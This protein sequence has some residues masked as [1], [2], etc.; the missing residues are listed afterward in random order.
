M[1]VKNLPNPYGFAILVDDNGKAFY[2]SS[3]D[4]L[5]KSVDNLINSGKCSGTSNPNPLASSGPSVSSN[6]SP[7][8]SQSYS[9][10]PSLSP[11][12]SPS[13]SPIDCA[14]LRQKYPTACGRWKVNTNTYV[15][16]PGCSQCNACYDRNNN[17]ISDLNNHGGYCKYSINNPFTFNPVTPFPPYGNPYPTQSSPLPVQSSPGQNPYQPPSNPNP[18]GSQPSTP[19]QQPSQIPS[20]CVN[21]PKGAST[22]DMYS[23]S[24]LIKVNDADGNS[25]VS[26]TI[27][28]NN[29]KEALIVTCGHA[30]R[31]SGG[32]GAI[33]VYVFGDNTLPDGQGTKVNGK[34]IQYTL[35]PAD[36]ALISIPSN[37]LKNLKAVGVAPKNYCV[38]PGDKVYIT[39]FDGGNIPSIFKNPQINSVN[40]FLGQNNIEVSDQSVEGRS[41]GGLFSSNGYLIG[42]NNAAIP[43]GE[44]LYMGLGEV[45]KILDNNG[46][47]SIYS[48]N[49]PSPV[50]GRV[51]L[52]GNDVLDS[53]SGSTYTTVDVSQDNTGTTHSTNKVVNPNSQAQYNGAILEFATDGCSVCK[54]MK[55]SGIIDQFSK[56]APVVQINPEKLPAY[57][58]NN[59]GVWSRYSDPNNPGILKIISPN[60]K[61]YDLVSYPTFI[62]TDSNGK[63]IRRIAGRAS[64]DSLRN[65]AKSIPVSYANNGNPTNTNP[66]SSVNQN[67]I[68]PAVGQGSQDETPNCKKGS[69]TWPTS[70]SQADGCCRQ[71]SITGFGFCGTCTSKVIPATYNVCPPLPTSPNKKC[72]DD[73]KQKCGDNPFT[74]NPSCS[75][76]ARARTANFVVTAND[77]CANYY[78]AVL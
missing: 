4:E 69:T 48:R 70:S 66:G 52:S 62:S 18:S 50:T 1:N 12:A 21:P 75:G 51:I 24:V 49:P 42:V 28:D 32:K 38:N 27:I 23:A 44:S 8:I 34:L 9:P 6:P 19:S 54:G 2:I 45:Q 14:E 37:N 64:L 39:G 47:S 36:I 15:Y 58:S 73:I 46:L 60:G 57:N 40:R 76:Q 26:G 31:D 68:V 3:T 78:A 16:C 74:P 65:L 33:S 55:D 25:G 67:P 63:E 22:S 29:G 35:S 72:T 13:Q 30:F 71:D 17:I 56:E 5:M 59:P 77:G 43:P 11:S 10:F 53:S 7:S 61:G 20:Q 41:G